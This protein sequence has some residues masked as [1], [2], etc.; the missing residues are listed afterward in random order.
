VSKFADFG[1]HL[2]MTAPLSF[3]GAAVGTSEVIIFNVFVVDLNCRGEV[4]INQISKFHLH[5]HVFLSSSDRL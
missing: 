4:F 1:R 5:R 2:A 3:D